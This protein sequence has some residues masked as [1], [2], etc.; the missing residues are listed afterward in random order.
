[1]SSERTARATEQVPGTLWSSANT[2]YHFSRCLHQESTINT[3]RWNSK[4]RAFQ[5]QLH[6][7]L[8]FTTKTPGRGFICKMGVRFQNKHQ[9][10]RQLH[11]LKA[12]H[13]TPSRHPRQHLQ[14]LRATVGPTYSALLLLPERITQQLLQDEDH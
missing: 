1:M 13:T 9:P 4:H 2:P 12:C 7:P 11:T 6:H 14:H 8:G 5:P 3:N 10:T